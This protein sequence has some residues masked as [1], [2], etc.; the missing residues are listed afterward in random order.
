[1]I[2]KSFIESWKV[3]YNHLVFY[4]TPSNLNYLRSFGFLLGVFLVLQIITGLL[5]FCYYS[6]ENAFNS[7]EYIIRNVQY[8]WLIRYSHT[9]GASFLFI[10]IFED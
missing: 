9:T 3:F 8:G 1:M 7:I 2:T 5:L 4:P 6:P 10:L